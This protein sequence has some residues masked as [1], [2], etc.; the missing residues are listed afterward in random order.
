MTAACLASTSYSL[1]GFA[2]VLY[3]GA[4]AVRALPEV[5]CVL[6]SVEAAGRGWESCTE[7]SLFFSA[8]RLIFGARWMMRGPTQKSSGTALFWR[9]PEVRLVQSETQLCSAEPLGHG[10][11]K[12]WTKNN[13]SLFGSWGSAR[14]MPWT[15]AKSMTRKGFRG[16]K[17][18]SQEGD[19]GKEQQEW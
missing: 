9:V 1:S 4:Q 7:L 19:K 17:R 5:L 2:L 3:N 15:S 10:V 14:S 13:G 18:A 6:H 16:R 12:S 8:F 11:R